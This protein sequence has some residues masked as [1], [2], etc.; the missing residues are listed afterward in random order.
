VEAETGPNAVCGTCGKEIAPR[1]KFCTGCGTPVPR[2]CQS[3]GADL[4]GAT[5]FCPS[6]GLAIAPPPV[7]P[8]GYVSSPPPGIGAPAPYS[9][10]QPP[11]VAAFGA[12]LADWG[13]RIVA[14]LIDGVLVGVPTIIILIILFVIEFAASGAFHCHTVSNQFHCSNLRGNEGWMWA[15]NSPLL[16]LMGGAYYALLNGLG[17]GQTVGNM[18]MGIAVR[19]RVDGCFNRHWQRHFALARPLASLHI[20]LHSRA[21]ERP[22]AAMGFSESNACRQSLQQRHDP[23]QVNLG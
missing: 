12:P 6:C 18:A 5:G 21:V 23:R 13:T 11:A 1:A 9:R 20:F 17:N 4:K 16:T 10:L 2:F 15:L 8:A 14:R 19:E 22:L 3:C 7:P